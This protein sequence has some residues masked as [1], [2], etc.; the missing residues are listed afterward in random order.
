ME[1]LISETMLSYNEYIA[2][3]PEGC[4]NIADCIRI[5]NLSAALKSILEFSE[6]VSWLIDANNVLEKNSF[7]NLLNTEKINEFLI[8]IN[9]GLEIQDYVVVAD[10]FEYEIKTFFEECTVYEISGNA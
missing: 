6:G 5:D 7:I 3:L 1:N 10:M 4:Q 9:N 8:E 2:K